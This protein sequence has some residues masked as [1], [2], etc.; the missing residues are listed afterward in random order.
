MT[1]AKE[2][3]LRLL[4]LLVFIVSCI[5]MV[6]DLIFL[7]FVHYHSQYR[8]LK[9]DDYTATVVSEEDYRLLSDPQNREVV[10]SNGTH[11]T[12]GEKWDSIVLPKYQAVDGGTTYVLVTLK[13][14]AP[15][16]S[17]WMASTLPVFVLSLVG[18]GISFRLLKKAA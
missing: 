17:T 10:L 15:F 8:L 13:G 5:W 9:P 16:V 14:T 3:H 1:A 7:R 4:I 6:W 2:H 18:I 12:K 11:V